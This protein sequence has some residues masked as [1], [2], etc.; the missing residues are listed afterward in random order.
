MFSLK[1]RNL[2][3]AILLIIQFSRPFAGVD[4][5]TPPPPA[6]SGQ[7]DVRFHPGPPLYAGDRI[8]VEVYS[9]TGA[10]LQDQQLSLSLE[11]A[12][13]RLLGT[14]KFV[15]VAG[16][17]FLASLPWFWNTDGLAAGT[18]ALQF[19]IKPAGTEWQQTVVLE[20]APA[21]TNAHWMTVHNSCCNVYVISG[22]AAARDLS[23]LLPEIDAQAQQVEHELDHQLS[24]KMDI[25]LLPVVLGQ[26]GFTTDQIYVSYADLNYT[27]TNFLFVLHHEMVHFVDNDMGGDLRPTILIEGLAVYMTGGH[28][29]DEPL[30]RRAA[31]LPELGRYIPLTNLA[32]NFYSWQ[33][34]ISYLEA[35]SL[36][37]FMVRTWG[38]DAYNKFYRDIHPVAGGSEAQAMDKALQVH[39]SLTLRQLDDRFLSYLQSIPVIPQLRDDVQLTVNLFDTIRLFQQVRQP[40]AYFQQVWLPDAKQMRQQGIVAD[41]LPRKIDPQDQVIEINLVDAGRL[42][43]KGDFNAAQKQLF[44]VSQEL[45]IVPAAIGVP[46]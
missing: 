3:F 4:A 37:E 11:G 33:H 26:S 46:H 23:I 28:Y 19:L 18:Y 8:S 22:T 10:K 41:Y 31:A 39:F 15:P 27:D 38:W 25:N 16:N 17:K 2:T 1:Y 5:Q 32:D 42:W 21:D 7:F 9:H 35:G 36:L 14:A 24:K 34:E 29:R 12:S 44:Q 43:L 40:S 45:K 13:S 20:T 30:S 6:S